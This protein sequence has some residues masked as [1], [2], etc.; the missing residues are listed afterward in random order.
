M[1]GAEGR[2]RKS[3]VNYLNK[4]DKTFAFVVHGSP[5]Q[6]VGLPDI[7][8]IKRGRIYA[9]EVKKNER[10]KPL[11]AQETIIEQINFCGGRAYVVCSLS[12]VKKIMEENS[13]PLD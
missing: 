9:F 5:F 10:L 11:K 1:A 6:Q 3:I 12:Q 13:C 8:C 4:L 2:I 7:F